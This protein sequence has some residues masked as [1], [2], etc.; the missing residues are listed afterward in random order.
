MKKKSF[1]TMTKIPEEETE[2]EGIPQ[3]EMAKVPQPKPRQSLRL[4]SK[5][6]SRLPRQYLATDGPNGDPMTK[7]GKDEVV[8]R[9]CKCTK[10]E[11]PRKLVETAIKATV[12]KPPCER[13]SYRGPKP[14]VPPKPRFCTK[15]QAESEKKSTVFP[16]KQKLPVKK[17]SQPSQGTS[18]GEHL[19][20]FTPPTK[21]ALPR[22]RISSP[23]EPIGEPPTP[24][25]PAI[26][27]YAPSPRSPRP[28]SEVSS[29][30]DFSDEEPELV[31]LAAM[32][33]SL[34]VKPLGDLFPTKCAEVGRPITLKR[35]VLPPPEPLTK[36]PIPSR[37]RKELAESSGKPFPKGKVPEK[38][39][40]KRI[41]TSASAT[42][43]LLLPPPEPTAPAPRGKPPDAQVIPAEPSAP[44]KTR[45]RHTAHCIYNKRGG[46]NYWA[47]KLLQIL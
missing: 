28:A 33:P 18:T 35:V 34:E 41:V 37:S 6:K 12:T 30:S 38:W 2:N 46:R 7:K 4:E 1:P 15:T 40:E 21:R 44:K 9:E 29:L 14:D 26:R 39:K 45:S 32:Q 31:T 16:P 43:V 42:T 5:G 47:A 27:V 24:D 19:S 25:E 36:A 11:Q 23:P 17:V 20:A 13:G 10:A 8:L 22:V 3:K